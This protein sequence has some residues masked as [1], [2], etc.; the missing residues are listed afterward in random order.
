MTKEHQECEIVTLGRLFRDRHASRSLERIWC[1]NSVRLV[2]IG[3]FARTS[4][5]CIIDFN[6]W[7]VTRKDVHQVRSWNSSFS[8]LRNHLTSLLSRFISKISLMNYMNYHLI[9]GL[10]FSSGFTVERVILDALLHLYKKLWPAVGQSVTH[11]LNLK[12]PVSGL[13]LNQK[14]IVKACKKF[15]S[16]NSFFLSSSVWKAWGTI[17]NKLELIRRGYS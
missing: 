12:T 15:G 3:V 10:L 4:F 6:P 7:T 16:M 8:T 13:H 11:Q 17:V 5:D 9:Y 2:I 1:L 14:V